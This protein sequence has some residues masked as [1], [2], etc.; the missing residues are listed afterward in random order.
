MHTQHAHV[1]WSAGDELLRIRHDAIAAW[2]ARRRGADAT[3]QGAP[4]RVRG[5]AA[6]CA[7]VGLGVA[8][9]LAPAMSPPGQAAARI[10]QAREIQRLATSWQLT[11]H[12]RDDALYLHPAFPPPTGRYRLLHAEASPLAST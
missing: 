5:A 4:G 11:N 10:A 8:S 2:K 12:P 7:I 9:A 3:A 6:A 1:P